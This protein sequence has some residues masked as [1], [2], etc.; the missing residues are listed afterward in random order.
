MTKY[1]YLSHLN[2]YL[3]TLPT[4]ERN[5]AIKYYDKY[6]TDAGLEN[7]QNVILSLGSPKALAERIINNEKNSF[8]TMMQET[9]DSVKNAQRKMDKSKRN[10]SCLLT[11]VLFPIWGGLILLFILAL[12][13][14]AL[15]VAGVLIFLAAAGIV[16]LCMSFPYISNTVSIGIFLLGLGLIMISISVLLFLP[17]MHFVFFAVKKIVTKAIGFVNTLLSGKADINK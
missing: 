10:L 9:K 12:A 17:A 1:D 4:K 6:F 5:A 8:S 14:F 15:S 13:A 3:Q 2:H 16:I 11:I 7:E